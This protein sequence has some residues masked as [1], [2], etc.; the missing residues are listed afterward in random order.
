ML[1]DGDCIVIGL[2]GGAD[3]VLLARYLLSVREE[4]HLKLLAVHVNHMLRGEEAERDQEFV[5]RFCE[6]WQLPLHVYKEDIRKLSRTSRMSLEEAGRK[7]RYEC[8]FRVLNEEGRPDGKIA[9]AHHANDLAETVIFRMIRGTGPEGLA[10]IRP[11]ND[12]IIRP[13]LGMKKEEVF[14]LLSRL[15]QDYVEDSTNACEDY[16][17]N[18][19]RST[20]LPEMEN[21]NP[22]VVEHFCALA[23]KAGE[24]ADYAADSVKESYEKQRQKTPEGCF[25]HENAFL[26]CSNY[27]RK[28][29][30]RRMLFEVSGRRKDIGEVHIEAVAGLMG[31]R[32]GKSRNLPYGMSACRQKE[33]LLLKT[34]PLEEKNPEK[35]VLEQEIPVPEFCDGKSWSA[36][37]AGGKLQLSFERYQGGEIEKKDCVK[38]FDYDKIK[39]KLFLRTRQT[40]DYIIMNNQGQ[41]KLLNRYFIDEKL[42]A[43]K[44]DRI[45]LLAQGHHVLWVLGGRISED[46]KIGPETT[47]VLKVSV[48]LPGDFM[49]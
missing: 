44:R 1:D 11:V 2:S 34:G 5:R 13:L 39:C 9:V 3:S 31:K 37:F 33:G 36:D 23:E 12:R 30:A 4:K 32:P 8:F 7:V 27:E 22:R 40:G 29:M 26:K 49:E 10:G 46:C 25:L 16:S 20:I 24:I 48:T 38:C 21:L 15:G 17:R 43:E 18:Y 47:R 6:K 42:P 35:N 45:L 14:K 41:H 19:I 28:E